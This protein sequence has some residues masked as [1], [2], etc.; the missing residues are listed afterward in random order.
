M[1]VIGDRFVV[2]ARSYLGV[3]FFHAGRNRHG[4]DCIGLLAVVAHDLDITQHDDVNYQPDPD[5]ALLTATLRRFCRRLEPFEGFPGPLE[6]GDLCQ[7]SIA[8]VERHAGVYATGATGQPSL[9]HA[10]ETAGCVLEHAF[11]VHWRR[12]LWAIYRLEER[13]SQP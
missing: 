6:P 12:R 2:Q 7:F 10:Y 5:P 11:D 3:R 4:L 9:I 1:S 8:G 13:P